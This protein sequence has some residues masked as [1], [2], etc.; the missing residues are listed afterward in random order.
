SRGDLTG[1]AMVAHSLNQFQTNLRPIAAIGANVA[2]TGQ[3][4]LLDAPAVISDPVR[5]STWV[6]SQL[7]R[8]ILE[9]RY[10]H[11]EKLPAER[12]FAVAFGASRATIR[13][14]LVRL[15]SE[16]LVTRR[17]GSGTFV[18]FQAGN[19]PEDVA[20]LTGPLELI[21]VRL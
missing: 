9:G 12:Q 17:L 11:G 20:E 19:D 7:R 14:A 3:S 5:G 13:T 1:R 2:E 10:V 15:E 16:R 8:A 6:T 4:T 18:N 21:D